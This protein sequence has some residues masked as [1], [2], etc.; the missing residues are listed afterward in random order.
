MKSKIYRKIDETEFFPS[1]ERIKHDLYE[2]IPKSVHFI[3]DPCC[4]DGGLECFEQDYDYT[5]FDI[6]DRSGGEFSVNVCDFLM[7][8]FCPA[9][10]GG[11]FDAVVMNPPFGLTEEFIKKSYEFTNDVFIVCPLKTIRKNH[12]LEVVDFR[13][14]WYYPLEFNNMIRV[15]IGLFHLKKSNN[16]NLLQKSSFEQLFEELPFEKTFAKTFYETMIPPKDKWFI[17]NRLTLTRV[18]RGHRL[19]QDMDIY[20]PGAEE[21]FNALNSNVSVKKGDKISRRIMEFDSLEKAKEFQKKYDDDS[22]WVRNYMYI[23]CPNI[24]SLNKIPL[25]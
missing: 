16:I 19:I 6:C 15:P 5:L 11:K 13:I 22:E 23:H 10:N 25:L 24:P 3:L 1:S 8:S 7:Q 4:G 9:P 17:V 12:S 14:K 18:E 20:Q 21:A 2:M